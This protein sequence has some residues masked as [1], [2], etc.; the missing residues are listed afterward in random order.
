MNDKRE[1]RIKSNGCIE[2]PDGIVQHK[3][4]GPY[5]PALIVR[6]GKLIVISG[7]SAIDPDGGIV[8]STIEE[9]TAYTMENCRRMLEKAG[10]HL[11]EVFKVS[12]FLKDISE[13]SRF[14]EVY[15]NYFSHPFPVRTTVATGLLPGLLI[16]VDLWACS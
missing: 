4:A 2:L 12:V 7:Q 8:G 15:R 9:Q 6:P 5:S 11:D 14:N 3:T 16:E 10:S 13:W 1:N